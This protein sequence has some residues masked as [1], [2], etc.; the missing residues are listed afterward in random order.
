MGD[1]EAGS[2][3]RQDRSE[4]HRLARIHAALG[5]LTGASPMNT[6]SV[7]TSIAALSSLSMLIGIVVAGPAAAKVLDRTLATVNGQAI[8]L[9]EFEKNATPIVDQ[10]QKM[11]PAA[12]QTPERLADIKKRVLDQ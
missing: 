9:S 2:A 3:E 1:Q 7:R 5:P 6:L 12:E 10:F 11:A 4:S 8:L